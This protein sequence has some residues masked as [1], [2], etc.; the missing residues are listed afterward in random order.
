MREHFLFGQ[1]KR[2]LLVAGLQALVLLD[3]VEHVVRDL[4]NH[5]LRRLLLGG[6]LRMER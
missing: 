2:F 4:P 6:S 1:R 3:S 5:V